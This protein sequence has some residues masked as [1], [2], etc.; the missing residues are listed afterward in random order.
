MKSANG[1]TSALR[2][3][4]SAFLAGAKVRGAGSR[5]SSTVMVPTSIEAAITK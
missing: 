1:S 2:S 5:D 4:S 3:Q